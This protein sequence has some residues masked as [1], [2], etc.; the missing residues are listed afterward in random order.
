MTEFDDVLAY[1]CSTARGRIRGDDEH[2]S[3][4]DEKK[5]EVYDHLKNTITLVEKVNDLDEL[6]RLGHD[7]RKMNKKIERFRA[8]KHGQARTTSADAD[9]ETRCIMVERELEVVKDALLENGRGSVKRKR[10]RPRGGR[11]VRVAVRCGEVSRNLGADVSLR[12]ELLVS[13]VGVVHGKGIL[14]DRDFFRGE[15]IISCTGKVRVASA[16]ADVEYDEHMCYSLDRVG[17]Q[18]KD[19]NLDTSLPGLNNMVCYINSA[20][21]HPSLFQNADICFDTH[22]PLLI[23]YAITT[24]HKGQELLVGYDF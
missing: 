13:E 19:L 16:S 24:I 10:G 15:A 14:A 6:T 3:P 11:D 1:V 7:V 17:E 21:G 18:Y 5:R 22:A 20:K 4:S 8:D 23:V 12:G 2:P 9:A